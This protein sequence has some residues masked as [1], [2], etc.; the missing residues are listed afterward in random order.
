MSKKIIAVALIMVL[1]V[2]MFTACKEKYIV[3]K[4]NGIEYPVVVDKEGN[5]I[6]NDKYQVAVYVTD[7]DGKVKKTDGEAQ[8]NWVELN[9][10]VLNEEMIQDAF[11]TL[12]IGEGWSADEIGR[13]VKDGTDG[14][15]YIKCAKVG[16]VTKE[17]PFKKYLETKEAQINE[18]IK[19]FEKENVKAELKKGTAN[20]NKGNLDCTTYVLTIYDA[21]NK[22]I[23]YAENFYYTRNDSIYKIEY[24]CLNGVGYDENFSLQSYLNI[25]YEARG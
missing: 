23:H 8:T 24:M 22:L 4:I 17:E 11:Y 15:C 13:M 3:E 25:N 21:N 2:T 6:I 12:T 19:E 5:T 10:V 1:M 16:Q 14:S 7:E 20:L 18:L 9:H